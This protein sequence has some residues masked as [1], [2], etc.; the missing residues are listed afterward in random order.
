MLPTELHPP[1]SSI[2][3]G[4][5]RLLDS[6]R[7]GGPGFFGVEDV[8]GEAGR[9]REGEDQGA[10]VGFG[11]TKRRWVVFFLVFLLAHMAGMLEW[12]AW[13]KLFRANETSSRTLCM[14]MRKLMSRGKKKRKQDRTPCFL[15]N[16]HLKK[17]KKKITVVHS[18]SIWFPR[19]DRFHV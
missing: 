8:L 2:R 13:S 15:R 5:S 3:R 9:S 12:N 7:R 17:E 1:S 11:G 19:V 6:V 16:H 18:G 14:S 10:P 4:R